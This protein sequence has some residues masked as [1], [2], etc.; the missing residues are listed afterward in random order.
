ME[1]YISPKNN[2]IINNASSKMLKDKFKIDINNEELSSFILDIQKEIISDYSAYNLK[3]LELNNI[4]LS[5]IKNKYE[6]YK[7]DKKDDSLLKNE[8]LDNDEM[9]LKLRELEARRRIVPQYPI[10]DINSN[11]TSQNI[12]PIYNNI[13]PVQNII[14]KANPIAIT[15]PNPIDNSITYKTFIINSHNRNWDKNPFRNNIKCTMSIDISNNAFF[16]YC[17]CFPTYVK[18]LSPYI[19]MNL[20][21]GQKNIIYT[22]ICK[23]KGSKWDIW[24]TINDIE[25]ISLTNKIWMIKFFDYTNNE[26]DLGQD[27][28]P[29]L[30]VNKKDNKFILKIATDT[31]YNNNFKENDV[32]SIRIS[33]TKIYNKNIISYDNGIICTV[34]D[35]D[36]I[37]ED[38]INAKILNM[39]NQYS[40]IIKYHYKI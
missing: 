23:E 4:T 18:D 1:E 7:P 25:D 19:L 36:L 10:D 22:F 12:T 32:I 35:E 6:K 20:S 33:N 13:P 5:K 30:E 14:Y 31:K 27:N 9:N 21:D 2:I 24:N 17:I 28:I 16:P 37:M 15:L 38:F 39:N 11:I 29:I 34:D 3:L 40:I 26:L 8:L